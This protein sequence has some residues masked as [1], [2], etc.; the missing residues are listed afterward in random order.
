MEVYCDDMD[1]PVLTANDK[2]F[3]WG[4]VGVGTFDDHGNFACIMLRGN[5]IDPIPSADGVNGPDLAL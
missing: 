5:Q 4:R 1:K 2:T 3:T